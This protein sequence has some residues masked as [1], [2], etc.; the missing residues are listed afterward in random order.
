MFNNSKGGIYDSRKKVIFLFLNGLHINYKTLGNY[1][2]IWDLIT[3]T[4]KK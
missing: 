4:C 2:I 3:L 1:K